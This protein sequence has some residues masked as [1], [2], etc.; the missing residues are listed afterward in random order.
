MCQS[1]DFQDC[2]WRFVTHLVYIGQGTNLNYASFLTQV[3][4][5]LASKPCCLLGVSKSRNGSYLLSY[6]L[7]MSISF[8]VAS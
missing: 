2:G 7:N 4:Q 3:S 6:S 5:S 1:P 8:L